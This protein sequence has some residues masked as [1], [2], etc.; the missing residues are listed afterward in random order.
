[1][2]FLLSQMMLHLDPGA[3][4]TLNWMARWPRRRSVQKDLLLLRLDRHW[5]GGKTFEGPDQSQKS[6]CLLFAHLLHSCARLRM[7]DGHVSS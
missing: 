1:M 6:F 2:G 3:V 7:L 4:A 5:L